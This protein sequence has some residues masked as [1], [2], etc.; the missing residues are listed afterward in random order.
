MCDPPTQA[1][2]RLPRKY[3][4]RNIS[5]GN[6]VRPSTYLNQRIMQSHEC[7]MDTHTPLPPSVPTTLPCLLNDRPT[8][9]HRMVWAGWARI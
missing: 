9:G 7:S 4:A 6:D 1:P 8:S 2:L 3:A 5:R